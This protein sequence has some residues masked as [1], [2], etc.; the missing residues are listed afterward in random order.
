MRSAD[1]STLLNTQITDA[2]GSYVFA[3]LSPGNYK[4]VNRSAANYA[5]SATQA[6]AGIST[7]NASTVNSIDVTL[8]SPTDLGASV[9][10]NRFVNVIGVFEE[11]N[12]SIA[13]YSTTLKIGQ[14]PAKAH[15]NT[16]SPNPSPEFWTLSV[17]LYNLLG[18]GVNGPYSVDAGAVP[19][20]TTPTGTGLPNNVRVS[21]IS[22]IT[23][24]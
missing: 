14:L 18:T 12:V 17:D 1:G 7:I 10:M 15:G 11:A 13:G 3:N 4:L 5:G 21:P 19:V 23:M 6:L 22:T 9:D 20:G 2:K 24:G 16:L 8:R